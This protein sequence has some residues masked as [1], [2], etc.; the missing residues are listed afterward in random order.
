MQNMSGVMFVVCFFFS[1]RRR[2]TRWTGDWS[3]DVCSSDL[4]FAGSRAHPTAESAGADDPQ[5]TRTSLA[6]DDPGAAHFRNPIG[7]QRSRNGVCGLSPR[8]SLEPV[9]ARRRAAAVARDAI[10]RM[11]VSLGADSAR[12]IVPLSEL[13]DVLFRAHPDQAIAAYDRAA[14]LARHHFGEH[15]DRLGAVLDREANA[16]RQMGEFGRAAALFAQADAAL[17]QDR[18]ERSQMLA[19]RGQLRLAMAR[20]PDA[21]SDLR[22][23]FLRR[24]VQMGEKAGIVWYDESLWGTALRGLGR[25]EQAEQGQRE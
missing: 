6:D 5:A 16:L 20:F 15:G 10:A 24:R 19:N 17:G 25:L 11:E 1:S 21:E 9:A 14:V 13:A 2:H 12:L 18:S 7:S 23:A 8:A 22:Q 3:S 4:G